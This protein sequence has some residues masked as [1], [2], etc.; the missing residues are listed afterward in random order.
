VRAPHPV[1]SIRPAV[2]IG[3]QFTPKPLIWFDY[4]RQ[5]PPREKEV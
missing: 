5:P 2:A 3:M 4:R 1:I